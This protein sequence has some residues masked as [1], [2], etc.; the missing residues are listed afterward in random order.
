MKK[1]LAKKTVKITNQSHAFKGY[2]SFFNVENLIFYNGDLQL[3]NTEPIIKNK[4]NALLSELEG[5]TFVTTLLEYKAIKHYIAHFIKKQEQL[6]MKL[7]FMMYLNCYV[8]VICTVI[9][10]FIGQG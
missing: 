2:T 8:T 7:T 9:Q 6:L 1:F 4:L 3:L 10:K 5:F